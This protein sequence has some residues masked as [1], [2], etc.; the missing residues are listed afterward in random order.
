MGVATEARLQV[1]QSMRAGG[2]KYSHVLVDHARVRQQHTEHLVFSSLIESRT[3]S[4]V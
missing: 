1:R 2:Y 4:R 3:E